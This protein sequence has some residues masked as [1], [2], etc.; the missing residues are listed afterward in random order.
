MSLRVNTNVEAFNAHRNLFNTSM[1]LSK[2]MEKLSKL[3]EVVRACYVDIFVDFHLSAFRDRRN[4][5]RPGPV[6]TIMKVL[7]TY[8][9]VYTANTLGAIAGLTGATTGAERRAGGSRSRDSR[10]SRPTARSAGT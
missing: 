6:Q 9:R 2:S 5:R 4:T 10:A 3:V 7:R 8:A 1:A